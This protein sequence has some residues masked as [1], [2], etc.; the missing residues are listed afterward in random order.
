[1]RGPRL[2][3]DAVDNWLTPVRQSVHDDGH[4]GIPENPPHRSG[5]EELGTALDA[6]VLAAGGR[7]GERALAL[8]AT[9][10]HGG[11]R[12]GSRRDPGPAAFLE[13]ARQPNSEDSAPREDPLRLRWCR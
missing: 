9:R 5:P 7:H 4:D 2:A 10:A 3:Q 11:T 1:M 6:E 12:R 13:V 8:A